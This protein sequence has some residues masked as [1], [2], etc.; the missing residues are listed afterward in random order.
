MGGKQVLSTG[1]PN[2]TRTL[3]IVSPEQIHK[4][5]LVAGTTRGSTSEFFAVKDT[6]NYYLNRGD[7][8][9]A[10]CVHEVGPESDVGFTFWATPPLRRPPL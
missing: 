6:R 7:V 5:R 9:G 3:V 4:T 10:M 2:F 1:L 8:C